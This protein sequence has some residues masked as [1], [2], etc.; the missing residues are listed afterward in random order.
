[1]VPKKQEIMW[2][3][4]L[5]AVVAFFSSIVLLRSILFLDEFKKS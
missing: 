5:I 1:M 4:V 2:L 3:I